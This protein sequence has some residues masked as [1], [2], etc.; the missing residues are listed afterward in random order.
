MATS[1]AILQSFLRDELKDKEL[2]DLSFEEL[3]K[4]SRAECGL[5]EIDPGQVN[6]AGKDDDI[7]FATLSPLLHGNNAI[8]LQE[9]ALY[10]VDLNADSKRVSIRLI[11]E[12]DELDSTAQ[13]SE[14][15]KS[16]RLQKQYNQL[17][18]ACSEKY[19][20]AR[21]KELD[22]IRALTGRAFTE[23]RSDDF[24]PSL[25][26]YLGILDKTDR[27]MFQYMNEKQ[28]EELTFNLKITLLLLAAQQKHEQDYQ[29]TEN[30]K[31][32]GEYIKRCSKFLIE[33]D[34]EYQ[35]RIEDYPKE[36]YP[37]PE[38]II[39]VAQAVKLEQ[40]DGQP[41][42]YLGI[43]LGQL[44][45]RDIVDLSGG[46]TKTIKDYMGAL[47]DKRLY[48]V[49]GSTFLKTVIG[50]ISEDW[51]YQQQASFAIKA[52]DPYTGNLS[53]ILYYARFA[54]NLFLLLKHTIKGSWMSAEEAKTPWQERFLTQWS[55]RKFTLLNDS[56]W[57]TANMVCFFW[58]TGKS[59]L[60]TAGDALTIALLVFDLAIA[61]WDFEEQRTKYNK[62]M[63]Q[64]DEDLERLAKRLQAL[65]DLELTS[66]LQDEELREKRQIEMQIRTLGREKAKCERDWQLQKVSLIT[67]IVYAIGLLA[68]FM[69]LTMPFMPIAAPALA[70]MALVG[71]ILCLAFTVINNAVKGGIELYKTDKAI[72]EQEDQAK[73]LIKTLKENYKKLTE[74][75]RKLLYLQIKQCEAETEYQKL[76]R[77][78]QIASLIHSTLIQ[79]LVPAVVF[80]SLVFVPLGIGIP[81]LIVAVAFAFATQLLVDALFK[82]EEKKALEFDNT[83]YQEFCDKILQDD[84]PKLEGPR[85]SFG[86]ESEKQP[87][88]EYEGS[89][90]VQGDILAMQAGC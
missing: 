12:P 84:Q 76:T 66:K 90:D 43:P 34:P 20:R 24:L 61:I 36:E 73:D 72:Q 53:W 55:L 81:A 54:L 70:T 6:F 77:R 80:A 56:F 9:G 68:A 85:F 64:Y 35:R 47:N 41:L 49:W 59:V 60:G 37:D 87:L 67:N 30:A 69:I 7:D 50:T 13:T 38:N 5:I 15:L 40:H 23:H 48:W 82:P 74:D 2:A 65:K 32:Y 26:F 58:L 27:V 17:K 11:E 31:K 16:L 75:E 8:V 79:L 52:P 29:K 3:L 19:K 42:K 39:K 83:D 33:L 46:T 78:Y 89:T 4:Y 88:L 10:Y 86:G 21:G 45:A 62:A 57:G 44:L 22:S 18:Q 14:Q 1:S 63:L 28:K 51:F 71:A 25:E